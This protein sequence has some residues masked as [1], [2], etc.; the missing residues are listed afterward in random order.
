MH[1]TTRHF[2]FRIYA[3]FFVLVI[4]F[5][6]VYSLGY[7][8]DWSNGRLIRNLFLNVQTIPR[9]ATVQLGTSGRYETPASLR[10]ST[11]T[12]QALAIEAP[13]YQP[14]N[15][16]IWTDLAA[17]TTTYLQ[18]VVLLPDLSQ[19]LAVLEETMNFLTFLPNNRFLA[20]Q[21]GQIYLYTYSPN[22]LS[23]PLLVESSISPAELLDSSWEKMAS[24]VYYDTRAKLVLFLNPTLA[25]WEIIDLTTVLPNIASFVPVNAATHLLLGSD[26]KLYFWDVSA[27]RVTYIDRGFQGLARVTG[28]ESIWLIR[29]S[30]VIRL[31]QDRVN[32]ANLVTAAEN[33]LFADLAKP[34]TDVVSFKV[35]RIYRGLALKVGPDLYFAAD[36]PAQTLGLIATDVATIAPAETAIFY[37]TFNGEVVMYNFLYNNQ[38][39]LTKVSPGEIE[40][41]TL[42]FDPLLYR[43]LLYFPKE[44]R[45]IWVDVQNYSNQIQTHS[46]VS[47]VQGQRCQKATVSRAQVCIV[48]TTLQ[49]YQNL[50]RF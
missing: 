2:F 43:V 8:F 38:K 16:Q 4:P 19:P 15:F 49:K 3:L 46:T 41:L 22:S 45:A 26:Q 34:V 39:I 36:T 27:A 20:E 33:F 14:E 12:P 30:Q 21:T 13:G 28:T 40:D 47:W 7:N 23:S 42:H 18:N 44:V 29:N 10:I 25:K 9:G 1:A 32:Y 48:G 35:G 24:T 31:N 6:V 50:Q 5:V 17:N 11:V 37:T